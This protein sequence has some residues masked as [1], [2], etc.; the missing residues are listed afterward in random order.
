MRTRFY[1]NPVLNFTNSVYK[2]VLPVRRKKDQ[3]RRRTL[4]KGRFCPYPDNT[5]KYSITFCNFLQLFFAK[6]AIKNDFG[7]LFAPCLSFRRLAA[8]AV[9]RGEKQG[10][11]R[12]GT[13]S[14]GAIFQSFRV[15]PIPQH[16]FKFGRERMAFTASPALSALRCSLQRPAGR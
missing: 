1:V 2:K 13:R 4:T 7:R 10:A 9:K 3:K 11:P 8:A 5:I 6:K 15:I 12:F 14:E 16:C